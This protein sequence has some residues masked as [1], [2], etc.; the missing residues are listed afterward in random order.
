MIFFSSSFRLNEC[1]EFSDEFDPDQI[2]HQ[3][4]SWHDAE[5]WSESFNYWLCLSLHLHPNLSNPTLSCN[6]QFK[7]SKNGITRK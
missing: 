6:L 3:R 4:I 5:Q 1:S 7:E 2:L